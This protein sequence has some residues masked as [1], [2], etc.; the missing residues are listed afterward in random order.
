MQV[1]YYGFDNKSWKAEVEALLEKWRW[2]VPP[3]ILQLLICTSGGDGC[4]EAELKH[5]YMIHKVSLYTNWLDD[6]EENRE[7]NFVHELVHSFT[8][9][10]HN[11]AMDICNKALADG[12]AKDIAKQLITERTEQTTVWVEHLLTKM[13]ERK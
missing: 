6:T 5:E 7:S 11:V 12:P 2:I 8:N 9:G 4:A 3:W 10:P 1:N 13:C